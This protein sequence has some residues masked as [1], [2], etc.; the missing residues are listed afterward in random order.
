MV[1]PKCFLPTFL[2]FLLVTELVARYESEKAPLFYH[3]MTAICSCPKF[4]E[5]FVLFIAVP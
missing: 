5:L 4:Y 3:W 2:L 1:F